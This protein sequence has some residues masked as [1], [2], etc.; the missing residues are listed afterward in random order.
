[1][2][3]YTNEAG[4]AILF[5]GGDA[6]EIDPEGDYTYSCPQDDLANPTTFT[7][8]YHMT[9]YSDLSESI[10]EAVDEIEQTEYE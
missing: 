9:P 5:I 3:I 4:R 2:D 7:P 1:M 10:R 6:W 8:P